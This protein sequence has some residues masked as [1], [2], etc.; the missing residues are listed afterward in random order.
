MIK[1]KLQA[2]KSGKVIFKL[3]IDEKD[4]TKILFKRALIE[5][6][7][8]KK[9]AGYN[10]E[11]PLRFFVPICSNM[12]KEELIID[13]KSILSYLEFSDYYD[14]NYYTE[15]TANE[16]YMKKWREEGCPEIYRIT[17]N[18][19][20]FEISKEVVFKKPKLSLKI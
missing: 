20:T 2:D 13:S 1:V 11:V 8:L 18:P 3:K 12:N 14:E 9:G 6:K 15:I 7:V 17:I 10:Y 16:K 19:D 5:G 4:R